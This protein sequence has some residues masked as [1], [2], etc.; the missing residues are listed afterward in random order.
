MRNRAWVSRWV[1][2][3]GMS[4]SVIVQVN[5]DGNIYYDIRDYDKLRELF[6]GIRQA[7]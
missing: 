7:T 6:G 4:D 1:Y 3:K 2:E 5:R